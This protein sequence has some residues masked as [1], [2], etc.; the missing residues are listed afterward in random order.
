M[1][2]QV[3]RPPYAVRSG[4]AGLGAGGDGEGDGEGEGGGFGGEGEGEGEG[5]TDGIGWGF[6]RCVGPGSGR[7]E[8]GAVAGA[9][10]GR[11]ATVVEGIV[12][13]GA[14]AGGVRVASVSALENAPHADA[15]SARTSTRGEDR[16]AS[17][18]PG[19]YGANA[20]RPGASPTQCAGHHPELVAPATDARGARP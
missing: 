8:G 19:L 4:A 9:V 1:S 11:T 14:M 3:P 10:V 18:R 13:E 5:K 20:V 15:V 2:I 16:R 6:R 12:V 17:T 7:T